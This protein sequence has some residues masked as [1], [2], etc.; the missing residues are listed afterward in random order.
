MQH[1]C[2][3]HWI[4]AI[5]LTSG[6]VIL[7]AGCSCSKTVDRTSAPLSEQAE[8]DNQPIE[9]RSPERDS[10]VVVPQSAEEPDVA[11]AAPDKAAPATSP[12]AEPK[13]S[14]GPVASSKRVG[15]SHVPPAPRSEQPAEAAEKARRLFA[16]SRAAAGNGDAE[17]A[18]EQGLAAY[19]HLAPHRGNAECD[20]VAGRVLTWL[21]EIGESGS[22]RSSPIP[23]RKRLNVD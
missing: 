1:G 9:A 11:K 14:E 2:V 5:A 18:L 8:A 13:K 23:N 16:R 19:N 3:H 22:L 12:R 10:P 6:M 17:E 4:W 15:G 21:E 20:E 7:G